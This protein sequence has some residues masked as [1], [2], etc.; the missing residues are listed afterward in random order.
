MMECAE[1]YEGAR[2]PELGRQTP[3]VRERPPA[4][5]R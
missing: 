1:L 3:L 2:L 5:F 4:K